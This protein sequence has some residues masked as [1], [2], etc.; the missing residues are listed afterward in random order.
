MG[1]RGASINA[2]FQYGHFL[3]NEATKYILT[4]EVFSFN[5]FRYIYW[6]LLLTPFSWW[7]FAL[8]SPCSVVVVGIVECWTFVGL[9]HLHHMT[10]ITLPSG[11]ANSAYIMLIQIVINKFFV[12]KICWHLFGTMALTH[13]VRGWDWDWAANTSLTNPTFHFQVKTIESASSISA[14]G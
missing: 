13:M 6:P 5:N 10:P 12:Q 1:V 3:V 8:W 4:S 14:V 9:L 11:G 2:S 7:L